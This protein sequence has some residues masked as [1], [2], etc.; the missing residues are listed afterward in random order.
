MVV[1]KCRQNFRFQRN[2]HNAH[3]ENAVKSLMAPRL[4]RINQVCNS[5]CGNR[6]TH[7]HTHTLTHTERLPYPSR[8]RQRLIIHTYSG[9]PLLYRQCSHLLYIVDN[10][11]ALWLFAPGLN[12]HLLPL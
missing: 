7:T 1:S 10:Y 2:P 4:H 8:M 9:V 6:E 3:L 11:S 5:W 12:E